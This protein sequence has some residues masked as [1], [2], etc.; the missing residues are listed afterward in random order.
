MK[1]WGNQRE[2]II[3]EKYEVES[4]H[5]FMQVYMHAQTFTKWLSCTR[6]CQGIPFLT[7]EILPSFPKND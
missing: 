2:L 6:Q 3:L 4:S 7:E 5:S 1:R